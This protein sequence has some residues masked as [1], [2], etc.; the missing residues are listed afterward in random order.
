M[1]SNSSLFS[2][3]SPEKTAEALVDGAQ[4]LHL[5][6]TEI[7]S[8]HKSLHPTISS[9]ERSQLFQESNLWSLGEKPK[10]PR[11]PS[12]DKQVATWQKSLQHPSRSMADVLN[13][14]AF[15]P[16]APAS[17]SESTALSVAARPARKLGGARKKKT[18][19]ARASTKGKGKGKG[20]MITTTSGGGGK[21]TRRRRKKKIKQEWSVRQPRNDLMKGLDGLTEAEAM[22]QWKES[23]GPQFSRLGKAMAAIQLYRKCVGE[24]DEIQADIMKE[25]ELERFEHSQT[26]DK[27]MAQETLFAEMLK[28][29][30]IMDRESRGASTDYIDDE[31]HSRLLEAASCSRNLETVIE[32]ARNLSE[33]CMDDVQRALDLKSQRLDDLEEEMNTTNHAMRDRISESTMLRVK[34]DRMTAECRRLEVKN[35]QLRATEGGLVH[36]AMTSQRAAAAS[37]RRRIKAEDVLARQSGEVAS[38]VH[39][40][41]DAT[42]KHFGYVPPGVK[43]VSVFFAPNVVQIP[44]PPAGRNLSSTELPL[45]L[46]Q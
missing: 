6:P 10:I 27:L 3:L 28:R 35:E 13:D 19:R 32:A 18:S 11:D 15:P 25:L 46:E 2:M 38:F 39:S 30:A 4:N 31:I 29:C 22:Q 5:T 14:Q 12:R 40:V 20:K 41:L 34:L 16:P 9:P 33:D 36:E 17:A 45:A 21:T 1:N 37:N 44:R 23:L 42:K 43:S 24:Q 8:L 7:I 26:Q